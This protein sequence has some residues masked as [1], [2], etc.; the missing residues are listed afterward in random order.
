M[1]R[2]DAVLALALLFA[3][4]PALALLDRAARRFA[5]EPVRPP[6]RR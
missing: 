6:V 1:I 3:L 4:P 5:A 2:A